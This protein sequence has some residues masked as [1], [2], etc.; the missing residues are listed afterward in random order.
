MDEDAHITVCPLP[1][2]WARLDKR[3]RELARERSLSLPP[4]P[5]ILAGWNF[6][7]DAEKQR[8]WNETIEWA[9]VYGLGHELSSLPIDAMY[10][11]AEVSSAVP[12]VNYT[13]GGHD[14]RLKLSREERKRLC[15][16]LRSNWSAIVGE[17][18]ASRTMPLRLTGR[19][20]RRLVVQADGAFKPP[21]GS[22]FR[23][24]G[25]KTAFTAFRAGINAHLA[26][27]QVDHVD[28][29]LRQKEGGV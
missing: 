18:L 7:S 3:L 26:P 12:Y 6:S 28:F 10:R 17:P 14:P 21:W 20:G 19:K 8:R 4:T 9:R 29:V 23:L 25:N 5:L 13:F 1:I 22:W 16:N 15:E 27:S 2:H 11:V 24:S